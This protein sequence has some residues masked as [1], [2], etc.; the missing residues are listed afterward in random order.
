[1]QKKNRMRA[2]T[3]VIIALLA[4]SLAVSVFAA[5]RMP[6]DGWT[7]Y[8]GRRENGSVNGS[9]NGN[10]NS[11]VGNGGGI[12]DYD[13]TNNY[14]GNTTDR[15]RNGRN[16]DTGSVTDGGV[17]GG[18]ITDNDIRDDVEDIVTEDR[19]TTDKV[20]DRDT[21]HAGILDN[22]DNNGKGTEILESIKDDMDEDGEVMGAMDKNGG[23]VGIV[24]AI[25][26]AVAVIVL[27]IALVP[28]GSAGM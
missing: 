12:V 28:K 4:L 11:P 13:T 5:D 27:I 8:S 15:Y 16:G 3:I 23:V 20:T 7:P 22:N 6:D 19:V 9:I 18:D 24:I 10:N 2:V 25:L 17:T 21:T 1:M 14:T 26:I